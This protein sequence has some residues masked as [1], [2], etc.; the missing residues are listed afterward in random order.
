MSR[1]LF[2]NLL[3]DFGSAGLNR[4]EQ[5]DNKQYIQEIL[6]EHDPHSTVSP[7][8]IRWGCRYH[9]KEQGVPMFKKWD[10]EAMDWVSEKDSTHDPEKYA[11]DDIFGYMTTEKGKLGQK[12]TGTTR[13]GAL[14]TNRAISLTV[15]DGTK[16]TYYN[17]GEKNNLSIHTT[18][19]HYTCY[20][21]GFAL[22]SRHLKEPSRI[23]NVIDS[24]IYLHK[25][26]GHI[27]DSLFDFSPASMVL[28]WTNDFCPRF[29]DCF[30]EDEN[31]GIIAP[32]L[33]RRVKG[34]DIKP[35]E[36][37][38]AGDIE[39]NL[40][41]ENAHRFIGIKEAAANIKQK[42][43][44]DLDVEIPESAKIKI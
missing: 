8:A 24:F 32:K 3:T 22:D 27:N 29:L 1:Y 20:Q 14:G 41:I 13:Q 30:R 6:K 7:F 12:G 16:F 23:F 31:L 25:V 42:I 21:Y 26:G 44:E 15:Y 34:G 2:G 33:E 37:W 36:L 19:V 4:G 9:L 17:S 35:E 40:Q 11:D 5:D 28:R 39:E 38:I 10:D 43:S 18:N